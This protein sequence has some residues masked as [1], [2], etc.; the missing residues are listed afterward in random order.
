MPQKKSKCNSPSVLSVSRRSSRVLSTLSL[1]QRSKSC[2]KPYRNRSAR[3]HQLI[4][5]MLASHITTISP[6][7]FPLNSAFS[8]SV[9]DRTC[10]TRTN[11]FEERRRGSSG[12]SS[13]A[14]YSL[15]R[16]H[17]FNLNLQASQRPESVICAPSHAVV[18]AVELRAGF[19]TTH[20]ALDQRVDEALERIN[21]QR[22]RF[23][24]PVKCE[25][26]RY[27]DW[28]VA[29]EAQRTTFERRGRILADI[30]KFIGFHTR[31]ELR[32]TRVN[33]RGVNRH[34]DHASLCR[35]IKRHDAAAFRE[36]A[37]PHRNAA[38]MVSFETWIGV[39]RV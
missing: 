24:N 17:A 9:T 34:V 7:R 13:M 16:L 35:A 37:S 19:R 30:E 12:K 18:G 31:I 32:I 4:V 38:K 15:V 11:Q 5:S 8:A 22:Q 2:A 26:A 36:L 39:P 14:V 10:Q 6:F 33:R 21:L 23:S 1:N 29:V 3:K 27:F 28:C 20:F 25:V